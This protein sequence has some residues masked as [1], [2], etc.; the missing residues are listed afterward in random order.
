MLETNQKVFYKKEAVVLLFI[1]LLGLLLRIYDLGSKSFWIDELLSIWHA[2]DII[3]LKEFLSSHQDNLHPPLYFLLLK[4]WAYGGSSELWLRLLSVFLGVLLIP[5]TYLLGRLFFSVH[6]SIL[7]ALFVACSPFHLLHD[8]EV[9]M[10]SLFPLLTIFSIYLFIKALRNGKIWY[11]LTYTVITILNTYTHYHAFIVLAFEWV[12]ILINYSRYKYLLKKFFISQIAI[13]CVFLAWLPALLFHIFGEGIN[14]GRF[15]TTIGVWIKPIYLFFSFSL[16]Q[17][18]LPWNYLIVFPAGIIFTYLTLR[19]VIKGGSENRD[20]VLFV[21]LLVIISICMALFISDLMPRY[22]IF[23]AP[24]YYLVIGEG[25][26]SINRREVKYFIVIFICMLMGY[27]S[28]NYYTNKE[29]HILATVDPWREV[30]Q[31]LKVNVKPD[32]VII[33][34]GGVPVNY[35][36]NFDMPLL[37]TNAFEEVNKLIIKKKPEQ[38]W[39]VVSNPLFK[40]EAG[41]VLDLMDKHYKKILEKNYFYDADWQTKSKYFKKDFLEYRI[42]IYKYA[43]N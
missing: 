12:Y 13:I 28:I 5:A 30:G 39:M 7:G 6:G 21:L 24:V 36:T 23:L 43:I 40:E 31:Y 15:P 26:S 22:M 25:I 35:Y 16:G 34:I 14:L 18:V 32:D 17:T 2:R 20:A 42:R 29:F 4:I 3:N 10:Y 11:W 41:K 27:S 8:R 37:G 38:I 1:M 33:N 9:R 19:F